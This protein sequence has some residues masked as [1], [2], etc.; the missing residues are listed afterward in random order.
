M[1]KKNGKRNKILYITLAI[2]LV[3]SL[4][5]AVS[6]VAIAAYTNSKNTQR[7]IATY[8]STGEKFSS[9][10]L[11][12]GVTEIATIITELNTDPKTTITICNFEQGK[13]SKPNTSAIT[14]NIEFRFVKKVAGEYVNATTAEVGDYTASIRASSGEELELDSSDNESLSANINGLTF[15]AGVAK[16][17]SFYVTLSRNF[18]TAVPKP[19]L[20]L[21]VVATPT[22]G[23]GVSVL[24]GV[25]NADIRSQEES[26]NWHGEFSEYDAEGSPSDYDAFNYLITGSGNGTFT[27]TW[28]GEYVKISDYSMIEL[29]KI[30]GATKVGNSISFSVDSSEID[31]YNVQFYR[32][33]DG[34]SDETTWDDVVEFVS[35]TFVE[36]V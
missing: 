19:N 29:L 15:A 8:D 34:F 6:G 1:E 22:S 7:T 13:I 11:K 12:R 10:Y 17:H 35:Y 14:Y 24:K 9:N 28:D 2:V 16:T 23:T 26:A 27:V 32:A 33:E 5:F 3:L 20:Y 18:A 36:S 31:R 21:S 30:D 4:S 25:F